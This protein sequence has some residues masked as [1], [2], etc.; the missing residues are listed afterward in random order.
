MATAIGPKNMNPTVESMP[1]LTEEFAYVVEKFGAPS[2]VAP[3]GKAML[4][5][6][7]GVLPGALLDFWELHGQGLMLDGKFQFCDPQ[8]FAPISQMIFGA[9]PQLPAER[10]HIYGFSAFGT[11]LVWSEDHGGVRV[12]LVEQVASA[13]ALTGREPKLSPDASI[14]VNLFGLDQEVL[15][16]VDTAGKGLFARARKVLGPLQPGQVYGLV[17]MLALGGARRLENLRIV[18]ALEHLSLLAQAGPIQLIDTSTMVMR[19]VRVL[20]S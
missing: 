13:P 19:P 6:Y 11:L 5:R 16:L 14:A 1:E 12:E 4:D 18:S 20:G 7:R 17:P 3:R 2:G 9:D 8:H 15:D 10:C